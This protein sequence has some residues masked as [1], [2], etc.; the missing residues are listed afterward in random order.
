VGAVGDL[1]EN[2]IQDVGKVHGVV[3]ASLI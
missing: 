3:A 1:I 2:V